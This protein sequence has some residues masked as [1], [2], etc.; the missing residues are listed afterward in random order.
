[1][2]EK[3]DDDDDDDSSSLLLSI[4]IYCI[5]YIYGT[6]CTHTVYVPGG[7]QSRQSRRRRYIIA[8]SSFVVKLRSP[9]DGCVRA[10]VVV[11][12]VAS[13]DAV[14]A[15]VMCK[16]CTMTYYTHPSVP[17]YVRTM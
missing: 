9:T 7:A 6:I 3:R 11:A 12:V 1:M 13:A 10:Y 5:R 14:H 4:F 8:H 17:T 16:M 15:G 2:A